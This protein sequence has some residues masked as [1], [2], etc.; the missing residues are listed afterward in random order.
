MA[1]QKAKCFLKVKG[2]FAAAKESISNTFQDIFKS[3][4]SWKSILWDS[5]IADEL[6]EKTMRFA[7]ILTAISVA[8]RFVSTT[9]IGIYL[10][11]D[12]LYSIYR[13]R[14]ELKLTKSWEED[15]PRFARIMLGILIIFNFYTLF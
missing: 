8:L 12:G 11:L 3:P 7:K 13:N 14:F 1:R 9:F 10:A 4:F 2:F 15:V 5:Y 6:P